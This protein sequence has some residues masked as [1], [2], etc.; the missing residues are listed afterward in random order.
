MEIN[1]RIENFKLVRKTEITELKGTLYEFEHIILKTPLLWLKRSDKNKTFAIT[2]KTPPQD[3]TGVFHILEHSVLNGST[4]YPIKEPFVELLKSSLQTFLNAMTFP[5]KTMYPVASRNETDFLNLIDVYLDGVF[6]PLIYEKPEI[7]YQEGWH[8]ELLPDQKL[9]YNGVVYNEMLGVFSSV[10]ALISTEM[11]RL[12]LPN[13]PYRYDSGGI[14]EHI[15]ELSYEQFIQTHQNY[16]HPS[17]AHVFL[18]GDIPLQRVL[19]KINTYF[20]A[21]QFKKVPITINKENPLTPQTITKYYPVQSDDQKDKAQ[22]A[23]GYLFAN[24]D[25]KEKRFAMQ[26]LLDVLCGSHESVLNQAIIDSKLA[27]QIKP[28]MTSDMQ[29]NYVQLTAENTQADRLTDI[30]T[31]LKTTLEK[32]VKEGLDHEELTASLNSLEFAWRQQRTSSVGL[33]YAMSTAKGWVYGEQPLDCLLVDDILN[34]LRLKIDTGY[35]ESLLEAIFLKN[36]HRATVVMVP[37]ITLETEKQEALAQSLKA[38]ADQLTAT[39]WQRLTQQQHALQ[40]YQNTANSVEDLASMPKLKLSEIE[41]EPEVYPLEVGN[42]QKQ[43]VLYSETDTQGIVYTTL[44]FNVAGIVEKQ[45]SAF[46]FFCDILGDVGTAHYSALQLQNIMKRDLGEFTTAM[47]MFPQSDHFDQ[48]HPYMIINVSALATKKTSLVTIIHEVLQATVFDNKKLIQSLLK[49][50]LLQLEKA[51]INAGHQLGLVRI[52]ASQSAA[53]VANEYVDGYSYYQWLKQLDQDFDTKID[54]L[55]KM[56]DYFK[57]N[58]FTQNR[59]TLG[60][61][62]AKDE[63]LVKSIY[64]GLIVGDQLKQDY[65]TLQPLPVVAEGITTS[66]NVSFATMG[67]NIKNLGITPT[68]VFYVANKLLSLDYLWNQ[69]R[70]Q[71]GAYGTGMQ[72]STSGFLGLYSYRD[73][74]PKRTLTVYQQIIDYLKQAQQD[75]TSLDDI[76]IGTISDIEPLLSARSKG[77][78]AIRHYFQGIDYQYRVTLRQEILNTKPQQLQEVAKAITLLLEK[79]GCCVIGAAKAVND[80]ELTNIFHI[81]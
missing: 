73:P 70:V 69:V 12:L 26:I 40:Q 55:I 43:T 17:N 4:K 1:T 59:L 76:I 21:Y 54:P 28:M 29:Q 38:T 47:Q 48:C 75:L 63:A 41:A 37:S 22:I 65:I 36:Q 64:Q 57:T 11:N 25:E 74:N 42:Y 6:N 20:Q 60:L 16:Y 34:S 44:Y 61:V 30:E 33:L 18:D 68:G 53:G 77:L 58:V 50:R 15:T 62:G 8:Y 72:L 10:D 9:A 13:T 27:E 23:F 19:K 71:G 31:V 51:F 14:P 45:L 32:V 78:T 39:D 2:F 79:G 35:Y 81:G 5:D 80:C 52:N 7:F 24:H 56:F 66:A 3:D 49:H 67:A 46:S